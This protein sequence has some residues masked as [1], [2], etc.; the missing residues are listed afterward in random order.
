MFAFGSF[1]RNLTRKGAIDRELGDELSAYVDLATKSKI[2]DGLSAADARR[3]T[4]LELGG[5]EQV[6]EEVRSSRAGFALNTAFADLRYGCRSLFHHPAFAVTAAITFGLGIGATTAVF[7]V[8]RGV[9]LK[10]LPYP[11]AEQLVAIGETGAHFDPVRY[12]NYLDWRAQQ[13]SFTEMA[14]RLPSGGVI[15]GDGQAERV[16]GRFVSASFFPTLGIQPRLGRAFTP[17]EDKIGGA[18]VMMM[19]DDLWRRHF[20]GDPAMIGKTIQYNAAPWTII[21]VL[22]P[23]FDFYG[24]HEENNDIFTPLGQ[25]QMNDSRGRGYPVRVTARLKPGVTLRQARAE[26]QTLARRSAAQYPEV[27]TGRAVDVH[28]FLDDYVG[29]T[30]QALSMLSGGV[31]LLLLIACANVANLTLARATTRGQEIAVR[32]ALGASRARIVRLLLGESLALAIV[33]SALGVLL[34]S[35]SVQAFKSLDF[36][37]V[38]DI[39]IDGWV[40]IAA[41]VASFASMLVFGLVPALHA[42]KPNID[43]TL[44]AGGRQL[45]G[46]RSQR[47]LRDGLVIAELAL[48]LVLLIAA[49]L[50]TKSFYRLMHVE[51]GFDT[52][53][54]VTF[55][56]RLPDEKYPEPQRATSFLD[57]ARHRIEQLPGVTRVA[58]A[59]GFAGARSNPVAFLI[60]GTPE[61]ALVTQ[62]PSAF[63]FAVS[64]GYHDVFGERL[65]AGR[66][67][68]EHDDTNSARVG[69]VDTEFVRQQFG[70]VAPSSVL[71]RRFRVEKT[72]RQ[73]VAEQRAESWYEIVGVVN[74]AV[75]N[76]IEEPARPEIYLPWKQIDLQ[77][78][79]AWIRALD[80]VVKT[81]A[82]LQSIAPAIARVVHEID[83]DQPLGS[84]SKSSWQ[85]GGV[86][87]VSSMIDEWIAPRR[88]NLTLIGIFAGAALILSAV[89]LYGVISYAVTQRRREIGV[90]IALGAAPADILRLILRNG[91][92]L[93]LCGIGIGVIGAFAGARVLSSMLYAVAPTDPLT[94]IGVSILLIGIALIASFIPARKAARVDPTVALRYE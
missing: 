39:K 3:T 20:G 85:M 69:I 59:T 12:E 4:M 8:V 47:R 88:L 53:N 27:D 71:G 9:I 75:Q 37:R 30:K 43:S 79:I 16:Y 50:L 31:V 74:H 24:R 66:R 73:A 49:G 25:L 84:V 68:N 2:S 90:R 15:T 70:D 17:E 36:P 10:S 78:N 67:F 18:R 83:P 41:A 91:L 45:A 21:G 94:F 60:E 65:I 6:K 11:H 72:P 82:D 93:A 55:R 33:G 35:W 58:L 46:S 22:P 81:S 54:V 56:L 57:E 64:E 48:A 42:A 26:I 38:E 76:A 23:D 80:F 89:G 63:Y 86:R 87:T 14:A 13:R 28:P 7:T 5:I 51:L 19:S 44:R 29:E 40:I 62:W 77:P 92:A 34:A 61:P 32:L 1:W 52:R